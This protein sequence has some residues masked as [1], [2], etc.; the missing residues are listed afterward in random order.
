MAM[1][2]ALIALARGRNEAVPVVTFGVA[3]NK[4]SSK[5]RDS[6]LQ[7]TRKTCFHHSKAQCAGISGG[8]R[9][10][11]GTRG[12]GIVSGANKSSKAVQ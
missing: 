3:G 1:H 2:Y 9:Q 4:K 10:R 8:V 11:V 5:C 6:G 12:L 7:F